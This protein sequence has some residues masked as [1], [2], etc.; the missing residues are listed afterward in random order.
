MAYNLSVFHQLI[1]PT[2]ILCIIP[3]P[4]ADFVII[5]D[6]GSSYEIGRQDLIPFSKTP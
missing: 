5:T 4:S 1:I 3:P 6:M 2:A